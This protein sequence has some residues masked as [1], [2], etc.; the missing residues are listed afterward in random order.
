MIAAAL[1]LDV[2][3]VTLGLEHRFQLLT[4]IATVGA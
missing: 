3:A 1:A 2:I 4:G